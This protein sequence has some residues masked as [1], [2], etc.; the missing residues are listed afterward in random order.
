[1][2]SPRVELHI[3]EL[4]LHG[5]APRDRRAVGEGVQREL[6]RLLMEGG[7]PAGWERGGEVTR[8]DGGSFQVT[9]SEPGVIG[10]RV[11]EAIYR[12]LGQ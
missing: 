2:T 9:G 8:L 5:V 7:V 6:T 10:I 3:D 11:A 4:V 12:S 1:M